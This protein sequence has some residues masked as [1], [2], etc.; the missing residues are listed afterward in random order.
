M[1]HELIGQYGSMRDLTISLK[2]VLPSGEVITTRSRAHKS[3]AGPDLTKC[4]LRDSLR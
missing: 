3:S 1:R 2:V 4:E